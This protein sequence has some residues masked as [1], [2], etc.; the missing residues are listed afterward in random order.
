MT[1]TTIAPVTAREQ[2]EIDRANASG[3]QPVVF[4]HGLWLLPSSW[5]AWAAE[6]EKRGYVAVSPGWPADPE[7]VAEA[8][9][10]PARYDGLGIREITDH[11]ALVISGL[12]RKPVLVGHSFGGLLV[13]LLADRGLAAATVSISPAPHRGVLPLPAAT[14]KA[15]LPVLGKPGKAKSH[16]MQTAEQFRYGFGNAVSAEESDALYREYHV[17]GTNRVLFQAALGNFLPGAVNALD[18][19]NPAR[20]PMLVIAASEDHTSGPAIAKAT[21]Q[22]Q[23]RNAASTEFHEYVGRGHSLVIDSGAAEVI[24]FSLD[25]ADRVVGSVVAA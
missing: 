4:V 8:I 6:A 19:K 11:L 9:A 24:G 18:V 21:Y 13:Q 15:S 23:S 5:A 17:P 20:G 12:K 1:T 16:F 25:Y 22:R 10:D 2:A 14:I 7:T 3:K